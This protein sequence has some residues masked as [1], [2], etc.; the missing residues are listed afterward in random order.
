MIEKEKNTPFDIFHANAY[1]KWYNFIFCLETLPEQKQQL[2]S[3]KLMQQLI[4]SLNLF[5]KH[6]F[7]R[8]THQNFSLFNINS[9]TEFAF[10]NA[11]S[12][13]TTYCDNMSIDNSL[14]IILDVVKEK[15]N[16]DDLTPD[17]LWYVC[18][19]M[20]KFVETSINVP[21]GALN[22]I[23]REQLLKVEFNSNENKYSL[24]WNKI[25]RYFVNSAGDNQIR[26]NSNVRIRLNIF[27]VVN[28]LLVV[29]I[30]GDP[31]YCAGKFSYDADMQTIISLNNAF[32][33][34]IFKK[35]EYAHVAEIINSI[36]S[37]A[38]YSKKLSTKELAAIDAE[39]ISALEVY[40]NL[41]EG[42]I[43]KLVI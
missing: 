41:P 27:N 33:E 9:Y 6:C 26:L 1:Y 4:P 38:E 5:I 34:T 16:A 18:H 3:V 13:F 37:D 30:A 36:I 39:I 42:Y 11:F 8:T 23:A 35:S 31:I 15:R 29:N 14:N 12:D 24:Y 21:I 43:Y 22:Q 7:E 32:K 25:K 40:Y 2:M 28:D 10:N 17:D 19:S 20:F